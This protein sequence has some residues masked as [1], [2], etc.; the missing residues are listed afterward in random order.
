MVLEEVIEGAL[1]KK[2]GHAFRDIIIMGLG[3]GG[4]VGLAVAL[5]L[6]SKHSTSDGP[7]SELGGIISL[8]GSLPA[9]SH[10]GS[11][12]FRKA[13]TPVLICG[14]NKNTQ[15]TKTRLEEVRKL[16]DQVAYEK[17][18]REGDGMARN[19]EE[20]WPIMRFLGRGLRSCAP[21]GSV[22]IG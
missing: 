22:E 5:A 10:P 16:F 21:E 2:C 19:R 13:S 6:H 20:M 8:G 4:M 17:W 14:G 15:I 12:K 18:D 1:V 11:F 7:Q 3:Q 9:S